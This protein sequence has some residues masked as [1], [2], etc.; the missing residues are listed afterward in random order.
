MS[1]NEHPFWNDG[2]ILYMD[3]EKYQL[4][5]TPA[6]VLVIQGVKDT[7]DSTTIND[8]L[9]SFDK[10]GKIGVIVQEL[11]E[12]SFVAMDMS[13]HDGEFVRLR[14]MGDS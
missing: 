10:E 3:A 11:P 13:G 5:D 8:W 1:K 6:D 7:V 9:K 4:G 12:G 2:R 14:T